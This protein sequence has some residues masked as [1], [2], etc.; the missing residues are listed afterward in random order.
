MSRERGLGHIKQYLKHND[1]RFKNQQVTRTGIEHGIKMLVFESLLG[2]GAISAILS[3]K[4]RRFRAIKFEELVFLV[5]IVNQK[6][7]IVEL[8]E[9]KAEWFDGCQNQYDGTRSMLE[10][11]LLIFVQRGAMGCPEGKLRVSLCR[12]HAGNGAGSTK[13]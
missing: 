11:A 10:L 4:Y 13:R 9:Q 12:N 5:T 6:K 2:K 8:L 1:H 7:W 3:F